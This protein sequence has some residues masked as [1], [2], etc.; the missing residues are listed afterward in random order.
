[1][2]TNIGTDVCAAVN[3]ERSVKLLL[4]YLYKPLCRSNSN[5]D[6]CLI[7]HTPQPQVVTVVDIIR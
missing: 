5:S 7:V 3:E 1:M 4:N 2:F 6:V